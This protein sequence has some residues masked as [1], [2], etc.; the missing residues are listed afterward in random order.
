MKLLVLH[1]LYCLLITHLNRSNRRQYF[2]VDHLVLVSFCTLGL[3]GEHIA[4][5]MPEKPGAQNIAACKNQGKQ[6]DLSM[7]TENQLKQCFW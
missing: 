7:I 4:H 1:E 6:C 3:V 2:S 5:P